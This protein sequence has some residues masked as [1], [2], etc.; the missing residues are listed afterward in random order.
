MGE[1]VTYEEFKQRA[2][3][4]CEAVKPGCYVHVCCGTYKSDGRDCWHI[5]TCAWPREGKNPDAPWYCE[6]YS[7]EEALAILESEAAKHRYSPEY[8]REVAEAMGLMR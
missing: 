6:A 4:I 7:P 8:V 1:G 2:F 3:A 5:A